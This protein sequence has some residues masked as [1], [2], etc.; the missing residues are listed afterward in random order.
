MN[1]NYAMVDWRF[2][3]Q[4][5]G[6]TTIA[7]LQTESLGALIPIINQIKQNGFNGISLTTNVPIDIST[8]ALSFYDQTPGASNPIKSLPPDTWKVVDYA[9]SL[10]LNVQ[11]QFNIVDHRNDHAI[12]TSTALGANFSISN[13]Y[14]SIQSYETQIGVIAQ[15]HKVDAISVGTF[16]QGF[17]GDPYF[18]RTTS[19]NANPIVTINT[20]STSQSLDLGVVKTAWQNVV[21]S[22]HSVFSGQLTYNTNV[23]SRNYVW[24]LVDYINANISTSLSTSLI[25][26]VNQLVSLYTANNLNK[27]QSLSSAYNK[28][29]SL[30][31]I[32]ID[33]SSKAS[34]D[35]NRWNE[36]LAGV[37]L[38]NVSPNYAE[39][40]ARIDGFFKFIHSKLE[41]VVNGVSMFE[42]SPWIQASWIQNPGSSLDSQRW[43]IYT[44]VASE[45]YNNTTAGIAF[46]EWL[47]YS[48]DPVTASSPN[49]VLKVYAGNHM[50]SG[51]SGINT[52]VFLNSYASSAV[53]KVG[54]TVTVQN[55]VDG[56]D[57]LKNIERL[58]FTDT[59]VAL[60][61][62][63]D[64]TAG[65]GYMLY[66]AAFNRTPD[67]GGLGYWISK[68]DAGVTYSSVAQSF[69]N[70]AEFKTAFGGSNPSVNTLVTKLYNNVLNRTPDAGG[71]AFWQD[72]LNTGWST[73]DVLGYFSTSG[74][75]VTNV[76]PLIANGISY[77]QYVG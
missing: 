5:T 57:T 40:A 1:K 46:Q 13:F 47:N 20:G 31:D 59:M 41:S 9:K 33:A 16:N 27:I 66:K 67:A 53:S 30:S 24:N 12:T 35:Q 22:L 2:A 71:L 11:I 25:Y 61:I 28:L 52:A 44:K 38:S 37:N 64:Q 77:T 7:G 75:N 10:G 74:E 62:G 14:Q 18:F 39:Q 70:S 65:S 42:F 51:L 48:N 32:Q 34:N 21:N 56:T 60:D 58:Q 15:Q 17:D 69:V 19:N 72:K 3:L 68:M 26:D 8:G 4:G 36:L 73:A 6:S 45:F 63:K 29:I 54:S 43:N 55:G 50:V 23:E 49:A 76:T